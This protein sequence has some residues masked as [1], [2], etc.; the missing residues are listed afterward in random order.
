MQQ[1]VQ[2]WKPDVESVMK[3]V[4]AQPAKA[5]KRVSAGGRVER[6]IRSLIEEGFTTYTGIA[7]E[8]NRRGLMT[9]AGKP[10]H[11]TAVRRLMK[12]MGID[13][14]L[15]VKNG[16]R[17]SSPL[18]CPRRPAPSLIRT[19]PGTSRPG[20]AEAGAPS[21]QPRPTGSGAERNARYMAPQRRHHTKPGPAERSG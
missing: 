18:R 4:D 13:S 16:G 12:Q 15:A 17:A 5:G 10:F 7:A 8:M 6:K 21:R 1:H 20:A 19:R 3:A 2:A 14:P 11:D 9:D